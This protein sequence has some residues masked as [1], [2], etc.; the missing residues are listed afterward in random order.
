[1]NFPK[2]KA[3]IDTTWWLYQRD[4]CKRDRCKKDLV[5]MKLWIIK[6]ELTALQSDIKVTK[7]HNVWVFQWHFSI[8]KLIFLLQD[9][10]SWQIVR[11][12][13]NVRGPPCENLQW[14]LSMWGFY[15]YFDLILCS[16]RLQIVLKLQ[17]LTESELIEQTRT[18]Y[19]RCDVLR[20]R[21]LKYFEDIVSFVVKSK[22]NMPI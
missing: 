13:F 21:I 22:R 4:R 2:L 16:Q 9:W 6:S 18:I 1:M 5:W 11:T 7:H 14:K 15:V 3:E 20:R 8:C 10:H 17:I 12:L 19:Y